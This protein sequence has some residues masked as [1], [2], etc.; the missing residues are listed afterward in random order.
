MELDVN[1]IYSRRRI[2][3]LRSSFGRMVARHRGHVAI[4][5]FFIRYDDLYQEFPF[6]PLGYED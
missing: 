2:H 1:S 4:A 6:Y 3:R 5:T